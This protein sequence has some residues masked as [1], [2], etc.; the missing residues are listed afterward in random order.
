MR[1]DC[2]NLAY[3]HNERNKRRLNKGRGI[4]C[5]CIGRLNLK[6]ELWIEVC[7]TVQE[8]V[9][10]TIPKKKKFKKAKWFSEEASQIAETRREV[11][12]K[13]ERQKYTQLNAEFQRIAKRGEKAFLNVQYKEKEE[14]NRMEKIVERPRENETEVIEFQLSY[15]KS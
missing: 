13:G 11:K 2:S 1:H 5:S 3:T 15:S 10:K 14:N 6:E 12:G 8:V 4:P 9:T 7:N